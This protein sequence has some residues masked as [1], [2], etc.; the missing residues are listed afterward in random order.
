MG[1]VGVAPRQHLWTSTAPSMSDSDPVCHCRRANRLTAPLCLANRR[2]PRRHRS[3]WRLRYAS[4][5]LHGVPSQ[6][7]PFSP[8]L[9]SPG[10]DAAPHHCRRRRSLPITHPSPYHHHIMFN[11]R[12]HLTRHQTAIRS[13]YTKPPDTFRCL[14]T[15]PLPHF[16]APISQLPFQPFPCPPIRH[17]IIS[18]LSRTASDVPSSLAVAGLTPTTPRF[19]V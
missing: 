10:A 11:K 9:R 18:T 7:K 2:R 8:G 3:Q 15:R 1:G 13:H 5:S 17:V 4:C 6:T 19:S 12:N 16:T 14:I